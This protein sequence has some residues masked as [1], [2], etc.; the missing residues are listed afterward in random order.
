MIISVTSGG[1]V[2]CR[3]NKY[4]YRLDTPQA[5]SFLGGFLNLP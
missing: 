3:A 1:D 2:N 4:N 5:R